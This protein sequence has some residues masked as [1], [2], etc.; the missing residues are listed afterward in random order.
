[1]APEWKARGRAREAPASIPKDE[2]DRDMQ[3]AMELIHRFVFAR[4]IRVKEQFYDFDPL[5]CGHCTASQF[6][7]TVSKLAASLTPKQIHSLAA[8]YTDEERAAHGNPQV[9]NYTRFVKAVDEIFMAQCLLEKPE[10]S[11]GRGSLESTPSPPMLRYTPAPTDNEALVDQVLNKMASLCN[12]HGLFVRDCYKSCE[13]GD[14]TSLITPR[15]T[16]KV[17]KAQFFQHFPFPREFQLKEMQMLVKRYETHSGDILFAALDKDL[18]SLSEEAAEPSA[19]TKLP[20]PPPGPRPNSTRPFSRGELP[21]SARETSRSS[22]RQSKMSFFGE[23]PSSPRWK[24]DII[25]G[26]VLGRVQALINEKRILLHGNFD[27]YDRLRKGHC[28]TGQA[29]S[30]FTVLRLD[31]ESREMEALLEAFLDQAGNFRYQDFV[32][33]MTKPDTSAD[34]RMSMTDTSPWARLTPRYLSRGQPS[35]DAE[36]ELY[37]AE[38]VMA[39]RAAVQNLPLRA[40]FQDFDR[41]KCG[42]VTQTQFERIIDQLGFQVTREQVGLVFQAYCDP[43]DPTRFLY[44]EFCRAIQARWQGVDFQD[45]TRAPLVMRGK[46]DPK[47]YNLAGDIVRYNGPRAPSAASMASRDRTY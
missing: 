39:K 13:R 22:F 20:T 3:A 43:D 32:A 6:Q 29:M 45:T 21:M 18:A 25:H 46:Y 9:V 4:R 37:K 44:P 7:R 31:L 10:L 30:V 34:C 1:M 24:K 19:M 41:T 42:R 36:D 5:R 12:A 14:A 2:L 27:E 16:G 47:Y 33:A 35:P 26:E 15:H 8:F 38:I 11:E 40:F 28:T 17:S 23:K